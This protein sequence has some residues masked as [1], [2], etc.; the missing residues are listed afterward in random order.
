MAKINK[1]YPVKDVIILTKGGSSIKKYSFKKSVRVLIDTNK[2]RIKIKPEGGEKIIL[3]TD[4]KV[5][6]HLIIDRELYLMKSES[7]FDYYQWLEYAPD[8]D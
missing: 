3:P 1:Y 7:D 2:N 5:I 6:R 8:C 4:Y